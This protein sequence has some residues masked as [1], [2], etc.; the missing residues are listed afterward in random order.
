MHKDGIPPDAR[1]FP[2]LSDAGQQMLD[3]LYGHCAAPLW[4]NRSGHRLL[5]EEL[6]LLAQHAKDVLNHRP[7]TAAHPDWLNAF[8][9]DLYRRVPFWR[10]KGQPPAHFEDIPSSSRVD[11]SRDIAR[12]VP[13][14]QPLTRLIFFSTSATTGHPLRIPSH[15]SVAARYLAFHRRALALFGIELKSRQGDVCVALLGFQRRCFTYA[16]VMPLQHEAGLVKLNLNPEGWQHPEDRACYLDDLAPELLTGDPLSFAELL[17]LPLKHRPR[18]IL[19]TSMTLTAGLRGELEKRF[20]C[21]V[22]DIYSMNEAGPIAVFDPER[23]GHL[24]LQNHLHVE[25][26]LADDRPAPPG[27]PGEI[28]LTGGFNSWLPLLRYRTGDWAVREAT[29]RGWLLRDFHGRP[30]VRFKTPDGRWLNNVDVSH[31]LAPFALAQSALHQ[32][33]DGA[34]HLFVRPFGQTNALT[35]ALLALFGANARIRVQA[36][37]AEDKIIQY[38]SDLKG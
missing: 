3:R 16:S 2:H 28:T 36:L 29:D 34:L 21:P 23:G 12:H 10:A 1:D 30:P 24:L 17:R 38:T 33:A 18:A 25:T 37:A 9:A 6:P 22:L 15:P 27:H 8:V 14:D 19:S 7:D 35:A 13:D 5:P 20:A 32:D 26:L 11:L 4:T 31:A